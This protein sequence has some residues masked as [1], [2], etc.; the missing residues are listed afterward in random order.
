KYFEKDKA[1]ERRFQQVLVEEPDREDAISILRGLKERYENHHRI[2]IRDEAIVAAVE[3]SQRYLPHRFLPDKAIDLV[4]EAASRLRI[5]ID[6]MPE[7]LDELNR[8]LMQ[9]EIEKQAMLRENNQD[10]VQTLDLDLEKI[11]EEAR[12]LSE[13]W[14]S[15]K[16]WVEQI[17]QCKQHL[18]Q[19]KVQAEQA[20]RAADYG[21]VAEIRYGKMKTVETE[22]QSLL[23][24]QKNA[25]SAGKLLREVVEYEDIAEVVARWTG[26]PVQRMLESERTKLLHLEDELHRR[27]IGQD[28]A[29]QAVA[30]AVRRNRTGLQDENRPV[31]T[32]L[33]M[34]PTGVGKTEL[35]KALALLLFND[36]QAMIR[37]D[38]SEYQEKHSVS[39]LIG[40]P[41][42][43]VGYDEG[44]QLTEAVRR[45]PYALVLLDEIEKAH[46]DVY[47]LLLQIMDEGRLTDNQGRTINFKNTLLIM[48]SNLGAGLEDEDGNRPEL[49]EL[50][51]S[52]FRPE[53]IN[54]IDEVV[55]FHP[56]S[57]EHI[58]SI[59]TLQL[60]ELQERLHKRQVQLTYTD[61]VVDYL[62]RNGYDPRYGARPLR[63]LIQKEVLNR[64]SSA[65]L[66]G[67]IH[68]P[69]AILLDW[70]EESGLVVVPS[71]SVS[72]EGL[73][74]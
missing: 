65:L 49:D 2:Q 42:G 11:K 51:R 4:D 72:L 15:E 7:A 64:L 50:L 59:A 20:E 67:E 12:V 71:S 21:Q 22:L 16:K 13:R 36:E 70:F 39:R 55:E 47:N 52:R 41:P 28:A 30:E 68:A 45:R 6:S 29:V 31:G 63:R 58:R 34:G 19:L 61:A 25:E 57:H 44:G 38:M 40:A 26:I 53:F 66:S 73:V 60:K 43:Y 27:V 23:E 10:K 62:A 56:L 48:T 32:F 24:Q 5:Q 3:L 46:T 14:Q 33:F 8:K 9:L 18:E 1:L 69:D 17:Q 54:R 74:S 35:T 37:I